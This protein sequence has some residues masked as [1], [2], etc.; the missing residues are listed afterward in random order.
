MYYNKLTAGAKTGLCRRLFSLY[1]VASL[2][3]TFGGSLLP[4][5]DVLIVNTRRISDKI[6]VTN[7]AVDGDLMY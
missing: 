1:I 5:L 7:V 3:P 6:S 4:S 2:L